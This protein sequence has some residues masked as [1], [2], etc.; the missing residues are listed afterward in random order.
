MALKKTDK[1]WMDGKMADWDDATIHVCA[2]VV[3]YGTAVFEGMRCYKTPMGSA[4]FR[5]DAHVKRLFDSAKVY[6]MD[7]PYSQEQ[8]SDAIK[9]TIRINKLEECYIR[10]VVYRGF[11]ELGVNPFNNPVNVF[12]VVWEWGK[13][14]GKEALEQGV[15]VCVSSWN[16][17]APNTMPA[18]AKCGANYMNSQLIKMEAIVNGY[19]EG[20]ALDTAGYV[21]EGSGENLFIVRD[22]KLVTPPLGASVLPGI[23]R[24]CVVKHAGDLGI[25]VI[26]QMIPR[27]SVYL[28]E[29]VFFTGSAAEITPIRSVDKIKVGNGKRGPITRE[30]QERFFGVLSGEIE[31]KYGWLTIL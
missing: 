5:L 10:P 31:D 30:L 26:E 27:E 2:H 23:T 19:V 15:D 11:E 28:A 1:I 21:S 9:E 6:R 25:E 24:D 12:I 8:I 20:I 7:P 3:H 29:E 16:R 13:Y 17:I 14:L 22:G 4:A 18:L